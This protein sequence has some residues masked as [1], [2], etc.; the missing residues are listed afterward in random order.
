[1]TIAT[2]G[3]AHVQSMIDILEK[4]L[5]HRRARPT[6]KS[7]EIYYELL[8]RYYQRINRAQED[9]QFMVGHTVM[10]PI[11][12]FYAMDIV[13]YHLE[14]TASTMAILLNRYGEF[15]D[16]A[17]AYGLAPETCSAHRILAAGFLQRVLPRPDLILWT[18]Q[19]CD[20]TA[21]AGDALMELYQVPGFFLDRP[22]RFIDRHVDYYR[23]QLAELVTLLEERTGR[24]LD[25]E[26]L[27]E[28]VRNSL[29]VLNLYREIY[30]L[31]KAIPA[32]M[33]NRTLMNQLIMEWTYCGTPEGIRFFETVRDEVKEN[34][35][36]GRGVV[37]DERHRILSLFL[38]PF[39]EYKLL[40]WMEREYGASIVMDPMSSWPM[41][42]EVDPEGDPLEAVARITFYRVGS[43][44]MHGPGDVFVEDSLRNAQ[45]FKADGALYF[46]HIGCRQ[47]CALIKTIKDA[48]ARELGLQT[49]VIDMDLMDPAFSSSD[50]IRNKLEEFFEMLED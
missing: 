15:L 49:A 33:R 37:A 23:R 1:M 17:R 12:L 10:A 41:E 24:R 31:R 6:T 45:E 47:A 22:Y 25:P 40:D 46:A 48:L 36:N 32:P 26:R 7:D 11:E 8:S 42:I 4:M 16:A 20:N 5:A 50:E 18:S 3:Q 19:A 27:R 30:H 28:V 29:R 34:V 39:Y 38:P 43:R 21:K 2:T 35:E 14:S 13:P 9:G 44:L